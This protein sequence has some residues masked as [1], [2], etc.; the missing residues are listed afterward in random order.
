M[1]VAFHAISFRDTRTL[2]ALASFEKQELIDDDARNKL[3][4]SLVARELLIRVDT[5]AKF[6]VASSY[7]ALDVLSEPPPR[8]SYTDPLSFKINL[9]S[10]GEVV[11]G[12]GSEKIIT[13][14]SLYAAVTV[15]RATPG[16]LKITF[17]ES[18][19]ASL[20]AFVVFRDQL[21][22]KGEVKGSSP[23]AIFP[24]E[25]GT[26]TNEPFLLFAQDARVLL[27]KVPA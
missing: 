4:D 14:A 2:L 23:E 7:L 15:A 11:A 27:S 8:S 17:N 6:T 25:T 9:A 3:R 16:S 21:P 24:I 18:L 1:P 19:P 20:P 10:T 12:D 13:K 26:V 22:I 5:S